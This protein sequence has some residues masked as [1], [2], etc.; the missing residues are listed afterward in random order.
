MITSPDNSCNKQTNF[1]TKVYV[2]I[3]FSAFFVF[4]QFGN[5]DV[6]LRMKT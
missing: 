4:F 1:C 5:N 2:M 6:T 3:D